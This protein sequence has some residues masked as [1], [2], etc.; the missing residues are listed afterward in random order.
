VVA[1]AA[2]RDLESLARGQADRGRTS[3]AS[4]HRDDRGRR[5]IIA[6]QMARTAS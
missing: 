4:A 5:S 6:F 2:D 1:A 3:A